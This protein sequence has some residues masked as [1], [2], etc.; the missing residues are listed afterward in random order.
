MNVGD[1]V[2]Q[3]PSFD[4]NSA[5]IGLHELT[6]GRL[7]RFVH[8]GIYGGEG[9]MFTASGHVELQDAGAANSIAVPHVW[10]NWRK[11]EEFL[12][13]RVGKPYDWAGWVMAAFEP[14]LTLFGVARF[15]RVATAYTC[16]SLIAAALIVDGDTHPL[17][18]YRT[19]TPDDIAKVLNV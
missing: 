2:F 8:C 12:Q 4:L 14:C 5:M 19:V 10:N 1:I 15:P 18:A 6:Q 13:T 17:L 16:S 11:V 3:K 7:V 9:K